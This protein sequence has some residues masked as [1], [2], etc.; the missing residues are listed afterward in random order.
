MNFKKIEIQNWGP[1]Q[2]MPPIQVDASENSPMVIIY[3]RNGKGKTSLFH[4]IYFALYG[5]DKT[6]FTLKQYANKFKI[7]EGKQ[8][9]VKISLTY[10]SQGKSIELTRGFEVVP[11]SNVEEFSIVNQYA[12]MRIDGG[13]PINEKSIDSFVRRDLPQEI[14]KFFLFDGEELKKMQNDLTNKSNDRRAIR[15]GIESLLGLPS[16]QYLLSEI[17]KMADTLDRTIQKGDKTFNA[18]QENQ[19]KL[20]EIEA[21]IKI[22]EEDYERNSERLR[23]VSEENTSL[24]TELENFES[25]T[26]DIG[27][28]KALHAQELQQKQ[29]IEDDQMKLKNYFETA[30]A[31]PI[32]EIVKKKSAEASNFESDKYRFKSEEFG[33]EQQIAGLK[34]QVENKVCSGCGRPTNISEEDLNKSIQELQLK[35]D[36]IRE[37]ISNLGSNRVDPIWSKLESTLNSVAPIILETDQSIRRGTYRLS[38]ILT[39]ST[40]IDNRLKQIGE[41][42]LQ[43]KIQKRDINLETIHDL[44]RNLVSQ[45]EEL[46]ELRKSRQKIKSKILGAQTTD[47]LTKVNLRYLE[48]L[49]E[50]VE[51]SIIDFKNLIRS[52][53]QDRASEHFVSILNNPDILGLE[54]T[55]DYQIYILHKVLGRKEGSYGQNFVLV[56]SLI[57]ALID[58]SGNGSS[59]LIDTPIARLDD[60]NAPAVWK[61]LANGSR[62]I[63]VLPQQKELDPET[64]SSLLSGKI[65]REYEIVGIRDD[66]WS[67]IKTLVSDR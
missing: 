32:L 64:A 38:E 15:D 22:T 26:Q 43:E 4:A 19:N 54:I 18:D 14:S 11:T 61:W 10:E 55:P 13:S 59:W 3:G 27:T 12:H 46:G 2:D 6:R 67:E 28:L 9:P 57:G 41:I 45:G 7:L 48:Q 44:E 62:Q 40:K 60:I 30:W 16:L 29:D 23:I 52:R 37:N 31:F 34:T 56:Y 8:F 20:T 65:S 53:V 49:E 25:A 5:E 42:G 51:S 66:A 50:I 17:G 24:L 47:P 63:I 1:Y 21:K 35:I 39:E 36:A 33:L 58:V